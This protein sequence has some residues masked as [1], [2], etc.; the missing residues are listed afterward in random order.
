MVKVHYSSLRPFTY[1]NVSDTYAYKLTCEYMSSLRHVDFSLSGDDSRP[2]RVWG[3]LVEA[4]IHTCT[5]HRGS[6]RI[7]RAIRCLRHVLVGRVVKV[8]TRVSS[9]FTGTAGR[10]ITTVALRWYRE[11]NWFLVR[12]RRVN[13]TR[14]NGVPL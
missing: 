5:R 11:W 9:V 2:V 8:N 4:E 12:R 14:I 13:M 3:E 1:I 6:V 7:V 10:C